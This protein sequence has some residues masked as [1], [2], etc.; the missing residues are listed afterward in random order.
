MVRLF[1]RHRVRATFYHSVAVIFLIV[2]GLQTCDAIDGNTAFWWG[3]VLFFADYLA[4]MYDPHPE[5]PGPWFRSHF[6]RFFD[7][8]KDIN[9][10]GTPDER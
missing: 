4:E 1:H 9:G 7:D 2:A 3:V 5:T 10:D 6:H 8:D